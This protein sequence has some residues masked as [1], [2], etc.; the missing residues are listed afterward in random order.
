MTNYCYNTFLLRG[1]KEDVEI[2]DQI[3]SAYHVVFGDYDL[4]IKEG[5][6]FE[7]IFP[8]NYKRLIKELSDG[9][10]KDKFEMDMFINN[11][12]YE[13]SNI[14]WGNHDIWQ[15]GVCVGGLD[16]IKN[17]D[18]HDIVEIRYSFDLKWHDCQPAIAKM[19][20]M[21]PELDFEFS[22]EEGG[23]QLAGYANYKN[24]CLDEERHCNVTG[25]YREFMLLYFESDYSLCDECEELHEDD[26]LDL[27]EDGKESCPSCGSTKILDWHT[28]RKS[29][30]FK[31]GIKEA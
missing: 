20:K 22:Y 9:S 17:A 31:H 8:L 1:T 24:G 13:Q 10:W 27:N 18:D 14:A 23:C 21:F 2:F 15:D 30:Q 6:S 29:I 7:N 19:A 12:I 11:W 16:A 28:T 5:Y 4:E 3:F 25:N 26:E